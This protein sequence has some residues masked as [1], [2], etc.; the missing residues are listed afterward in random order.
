MER[1]VRNRSHIVL[2]RVHRLRVETVFTLLFCFLYMFA[3]P[4]I[5]I[6]GENEVYTTWQTD[7]VGFEATNEVWLDCHKL[8]V[9]KLIVRCIKAMSEFL[10]R[11]QYLAIFE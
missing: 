3:Y 5:P 8:S 10:S 4:D 1:F 9:A 11:L 6:E 7:K 2:V